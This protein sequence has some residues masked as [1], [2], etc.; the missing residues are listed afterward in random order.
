MTGI[1]H[2]LGNITKEIKII[3]WSLMENLELKSISEIK[4]TNGV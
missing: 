3:K 4:F 2:Q 1:N